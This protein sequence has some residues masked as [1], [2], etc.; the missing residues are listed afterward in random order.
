MTRSDNARKEDED[1]PERSDGAGITYDRDDDES[2]SATVVRAV[3]VATDR[4]PL[5]LPPLGDHVDADD[6]DGLVGSS[7]GESGVRV[8]FRFAGCD[9]RVAGDGWVAVDPSAA[10]LDGGGR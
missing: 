5:A 1:G 8:S 9:V 7:D 10:V 4:E 2:P 6:L 3:A